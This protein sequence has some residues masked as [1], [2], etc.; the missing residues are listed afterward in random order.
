MKSLENRNEEKLEK[1]EVE[2]EEDERKKKRRQKRR[3]NKA[4][5]KQGQSG[6]EKN[7]TIKSANSAK[8]FIC[9]ECSKLVLDED[10]PLLKRS[11]LPSEHFT[12][13]SCLLKQGA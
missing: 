12:C 5:K 10:I 13:I 3:Q 7:Q 4:N 8:M 11:S 2:K 6:L 9:Y 1:E